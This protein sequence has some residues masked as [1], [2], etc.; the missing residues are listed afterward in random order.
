MNLT[1]T[2][3]GYWKVMNDWSSCTVACGGGTQT[4]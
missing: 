1:E 4:L 3:D 2:V